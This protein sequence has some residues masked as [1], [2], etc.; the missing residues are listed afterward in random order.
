MLANISTTSTCYNQ[1]LTNFFM[2]G[3]W[4]SEQRNGDGGVMT[5]SWEGVVGSRGGGRTFGDGGGG[6]Q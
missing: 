4:R 5:T 6:W 3:S 2:H 1:L